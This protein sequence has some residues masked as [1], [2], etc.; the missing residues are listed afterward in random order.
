MA[1]IL[2]SEL[3]EFLNSHHLVSLGLWPNVS[4]VHLARMRGNC[5]DYLKIG[6]KIYYPKSS[7]IE[8]IEKN[9]NEARKEEQDDRDKAATVSN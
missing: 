7:V 2:N 3:P 5:P 9:M 1:C 6:K 8:F 4:A